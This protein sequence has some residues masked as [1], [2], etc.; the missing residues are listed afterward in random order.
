MAANALKMGQEKKKEKKD[1]QSGIRLEVQR[2]QNMTVRDM[3]IVCKWRGGSTFTSLTS[4][5]A[6]GVK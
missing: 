6:N 2:S 4:T 5:K 1:K 3:M